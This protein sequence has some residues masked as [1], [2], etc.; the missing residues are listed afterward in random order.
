MVQSY[1]LLHTIALGLACLMPGYGAIAAAQTGADSIH[2]PVVQRLDYI[3]DLDATDGLSATEANKLTSWLTA[4]SPA[5]G[6]SIGLDPASDVNDA[7][8]RTAIATILGQY[9]L[10]LAASAPV[11]QGLLAP[12]HV[13][14]VLSRMTASV[15]GCPDWSRPMATNSAR[16]NLSNFG[17]ATNATLAAM[18]ADPSDLLVGRKARPATISP[19]SGRVIEA[20][21]TNG[22]AAAGAGASAAA[23]AGASQAGASPK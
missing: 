20:Y 5:Y 7:T 14:V 17:C 9:G 18:V 1:P 2:Q 6:D 15:P 3:L 16:R 10:A 12:G 23:S 11:T 19:V 4:L 13:R 8:V 21:R 22:P